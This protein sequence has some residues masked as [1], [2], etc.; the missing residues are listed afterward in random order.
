MTYLEQLYYLL[1]VLVVV[2]GGC[3]L[4]LLEAFARAGSRRWLMHLGVAVCVAA[5]LATW[6]VW[7]RVGETGDVTIF[8]GMIL[9][10]R[11]GLFLALVFTVAT[12]LAMLIS[13]DFFR[14]HAFLYGELYPLLL[15]ATAGMMVLAMAGD[16]VSVFLGVE[17]M[18]LAAYIMTGAFR[19]AKRPSEA[20]LKYF[21]TGAF[22][23]AILL[24]GIALV[25]GAVGDTNLLVIRQATAAHGEPIFLVGMF[26]LIVAMGFKIAAVPFHM[27]APDAYEGAPTPVTG[28]MAAGVKAAGIAGILR[29]FVYGFG[30]EILP[31]GQLGWATIL[32][33]L[34]VLTMTVGNVAALRQEN[35]KRMLAYSSI[36]HAGYLLI[37]VV[38]AGVA[39]EGLDLARPALLYYLLAYT[40]TTLGA[41]GVVA[42]VGRRGDERPLVDDW[43]GLGARHPAAALA[44]TLFLLSLG[45]IPPTGGF[46][47]KFYVFRAA[48][49]PDGQLLWLV[50]AGVLNSVISIFYYL[51]V[52][53]AMYFREPTREAQPP[54]SGAITAALA[55]CAVLVLA[56]GL[57]PETWLDLSSA[58]MMLGMPRP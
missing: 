45:G 39:G 54:A 56:M 11:F 34:A 44:M 38:A 58:S 2:I 7:R 15:F 36:A 30:G 25:Y 5:A 42:W 41:F 19:R 10:D 21:L 40:F 28:Y 35:I 27:W 53:V 51:R 8:D 31:Y 33:I 55:I 3:V 12:L 52:V 6:L 24:Y 9:A 43:A 37:G 4:L 26:M 47:G 14:E 57:L 29:V 46:F 32:A 23:T 50:I 17:I 20:A 22:A 49:E 18:S 16:L 1:P 13:A 48:M